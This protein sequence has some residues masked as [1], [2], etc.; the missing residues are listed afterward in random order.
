M[1]ISLK[2][3]RDGDSHSLRGA[4]SY[5][6]SAKQLR[7]FHIREIPLEIL[8]T[9]KNN[10]TLFF[11]DGE[12]EFNADTPGLKR[13]YVGEATSG[14]GIAPN[15]KGLADAK[16]PSKETKKLQNNP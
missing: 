15:R 7:E 5:K 12:N 3:V 10:Q 1:L 2:S 14:S 6:D 11:A 8:E 4:V 13:V 16:K 9:G